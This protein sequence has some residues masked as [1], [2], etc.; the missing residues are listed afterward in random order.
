M[1]ING[2]SSDGQWLSTKMLCTLSLGCLL[3]NLLVVTPVMMFLGFSLASIVNPD[4][5]ALKEITK[6]VREGQ[7]GLVYLKVK[8]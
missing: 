3:L 1:F 6:L 5:E 8:Q 2:K 4:V 7:H